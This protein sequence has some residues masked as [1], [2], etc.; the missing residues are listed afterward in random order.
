[1]IM[2]QF[3]TRQERNPKQGIYEVHQIRNASLPSSIFEQQTGHPSF[4]LPLPFTV[5]PDQSFYKAVLVP[6]GRSG[7][8]DYSTT[9]WHSLDHEMI[10]VSI[11]TRAIL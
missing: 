6:T 2:N 7:P 10:A 11:D 8:F 1:M 5:A 4:S 3:R 9:G